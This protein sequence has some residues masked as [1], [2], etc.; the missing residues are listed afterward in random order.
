[1]WSQK[2]PTSKFFQFEGK[3][4]NLQKPRGKDLTDLQLS[5]RSD[6]FER[7]KRGCALNTPAKVL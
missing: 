2:C 3:S 4:Y 5:D 6:N 1:M 7:I